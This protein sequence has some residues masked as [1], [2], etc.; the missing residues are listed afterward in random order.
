MACS[1]LHM[2]VQPD[3]AC[4]GAFF[5]RLACA[6]TTCD[7]DLVQIDP[8]KSV[9]EHVEPQLQEIMSRSFTITLEY[10][11]VNGFGGPSSWECVVMYWKQVLDTAFIHA[12]DIMPKPV[13]DAVR[14]LINFLSLVPF[15]Q[16]AFLPTWGED[17]SIR[18]V[19]ELLCPLKSLMPD[20]MREDALKLNG[21]SETMIASFEKLATDVQCEGYAK[22]LAI[23]WQ[24]IAPATPLPIQIQCRL[25]DAIA[26]CLL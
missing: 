13:L 24:Y 4:D 3:Q 5:E 10:L 17:V 6:W 23:I 21:M 20:M 22:A 26:I 19:A 11:K 1:I 7:R 9:Y 18:D 15:V 2:E 25:N 8:P 16:S 12:H 14:F